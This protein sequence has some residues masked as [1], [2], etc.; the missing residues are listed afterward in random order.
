MSRI[1][2]DL[3]GAGVSVLSAEDSR[4]VTTTVLTCS[5]ACR[6]C[7]LRSDAVDRNRKRGHYRPMSMAVKRSQ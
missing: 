6:R 5:A 1:G 2:N 4:A 7:G 3:H